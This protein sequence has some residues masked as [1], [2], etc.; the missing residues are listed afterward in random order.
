[1]QRPGRGLQAVRRHAIKSVGERS[2]CVSA[3]HSV[4]VTCKYRLL[5]KD[6]Q[7][8]NFICLKATHFG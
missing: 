2:A 5:K 6:F 7:K 8:L 4:Q 1:M 3:A